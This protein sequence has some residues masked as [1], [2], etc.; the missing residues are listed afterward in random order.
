M[1]LLVK[2]LLH[3]VSNMPNR[4]KL[5]PELEQSCKIEYVAFKEANKMSYKATLSSIKFKANYFTQWAEGN[6]FSEDIKKL[7]GLRRWP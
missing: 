6:F 1:D 7:T 5:L 4:T 3:F 2:Y